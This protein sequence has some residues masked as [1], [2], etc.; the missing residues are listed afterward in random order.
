M[1]RKVSVN[2]NAAQRITFRSGPDNIHIE[3]LVYA[4]SPTSGH[5]YINIDNDHVSAYYWSHAGKSILEFLSKA[6][7]EYLIGKFFPKLNPTI[8]DSNYRNFLSYIAKKYGEEIRELYRNDQKGEFKNLLR[9]AYDAV[10]YEELT[11]ELLYNDSDTFGFFEKLGVDWFETPLLPKLENPQYKYMYECFE[12][13]K[14]VLTDNLSTISEHQ[15]KL[16]HV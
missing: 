10:L 2:L 13:I 12:S 16:C 5:A 7:T 8:N 3:L 14:Q 9:G 15:E 4:T 11:E 6:S 1:E